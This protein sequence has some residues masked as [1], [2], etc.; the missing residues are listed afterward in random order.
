MKMAQVL[1]SVVASFSYKK[2]NL[3]IISPS[4][5]ESQRSVALFSEPVIQGGKFSININTVNHDQSPKLTLEASS[6]PEAL[7]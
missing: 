1:S 2:A 6:P 3:A 7:S 5:S 4:G